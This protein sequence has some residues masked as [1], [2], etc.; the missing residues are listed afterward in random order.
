MIIV[1]IVG[2]LISS[3]KDVEDRVKI[4]RDN[5]TVPKK[6]IELIFQSLFQIPIHSGDMVPQLH[7]DKLAIISKH[8]HCA[9]NNRPPISR[10]EL[11]T[12]TINYSMIWQGIT[13]GQLNQKLT[14]K[15]LQQQDEWKDWSKSEYEEL[16]SYESLDMFGAPCQRPH[17]SNVLPL[18]WT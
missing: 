6:P 10:D 14:R 8:H 7:F 9:R 5:Q 15:F 4:F 17:K 18:I 16:D 13:H 11:D 1:S 12:N 3:V 2:K